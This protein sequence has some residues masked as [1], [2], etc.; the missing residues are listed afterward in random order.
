MEMS[1]KNEIA[2]KIDG[3]KDCSE[4]APLMKAFI[5]LMEV[6]FQKCAASVVRL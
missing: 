2:S 6:R 4:V 3:W 5:E 1:N